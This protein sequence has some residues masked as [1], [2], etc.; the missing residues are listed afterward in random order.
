VWAA[1]DEPVRVGSPDMASEE[2]AQDPTAPRPVLDHQ[3]P[4]T[5][6]AA[7]RN[8]ASRHGHRR[9][10]GR[11]DPRR[12]RAH[13][14]LPPTAAKMRERSRLVLQRRLDGSQTEEKQLRIERPELSVPDD[15]SADADARADDRQAQDSLRYRRDSRSARP[16]DVSD[17]R[18][19]GS[20]ECGGGPMGRTFGGLPPDERFVATVS[21]ICYET[22]GVAATVTTIVF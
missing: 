14:P 22:S 6:G 5:R 15:S 19:S 9:P 18:T 2:A 13:G 3:R 17:R 20:S 1:A 16:G 8:T 21:L 12:R 7:L 10:V 11:H 4:R